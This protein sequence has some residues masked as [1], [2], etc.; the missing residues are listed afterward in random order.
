MFAIMEELYVFFSASTKRFQP[1]QEK[2]SAIEN[3]LQLTNLSNTRW[4]A[5]AESIRAVD[6]SLEAIA[7]FLY[8][9]SISIKF[10]AK[11][12]TKA[13]G[14]YKRVLSF[15]FIVSVMFM[16]NVMYKVKMLTESLES[17]QLNVIDAVSLIGHTTKSLMFINLDMNGMDGLI[18]SAQ[19]FANKLGIDSEDDFS[20]HHRRRV[21][22]KRI[23]EKRDNEANLTFKQFYLKEFKA[24]LDS[25]IGMLDSN[26]KT[27]METLKPLFDIF[28]FPVS[29]NNLTIDKLNEA[30]NMFPSMDAKPDVY[31]LQAELEVLFD[32]CPNVNKMA[33]VTEKA[34]EMKDMLKL[35]FRL[36][37]FVN[38]AGVSVSTNERRFSKLKFVKTQLRSTMADDRL[39]RLMLLACEKDL[40]DNVDFS[41]LISSWAKLKERRIRVSA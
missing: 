21:A 36:I 2:F 19:T 11:T 16:K 5:R 28:A 39:D 31:A 8:D 40:T 24:V 13:H 17:M 15:D 34:C 22:P 41:G 26:M 35:A 9:M 12:K 18:D 20:R 32:N 33:D 30:L 10:D 38:T 3:S 23:D 27:C 1:L 4:T 37:R 6:A 29:R 7:A 25:L 14:L